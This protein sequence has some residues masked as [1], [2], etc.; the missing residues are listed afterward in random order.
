MVIYV[1]SQAASVARLKRALEEA[2]LLC[3]T[4]LVG[5]GPAA[6]I[7]VSEAEVEDAQAVLARAMGE[8]RHEQ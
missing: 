2:G 4:R 8:G 3:Q 7:L 6:E 5:Q 1:G